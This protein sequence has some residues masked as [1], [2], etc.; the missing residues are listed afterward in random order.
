MF[1][2][3]L[4][5]APGTTMGK[6]PKHLRGF[7]HEMQDRQGLQPPKQGTGRKRLITLP[8]LP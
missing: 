4:W 8:P 1:W 5:S 7:S 6:G 2:E 3:N